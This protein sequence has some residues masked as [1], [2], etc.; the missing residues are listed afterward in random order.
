MTEGNFILATSLISSVPRT[1]DSKHTFPKHFRNNPLPDPYTVPLFP[2]QQ[3]RTNLVEYVPKPASHH[4][5]HENERL[6]NKARLE[7]QYDWQCTNTLDFASINP[8]G[9]N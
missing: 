6:G 1:M 5:Q 8:G 9:S 3:S 7:G 4:L 2:K